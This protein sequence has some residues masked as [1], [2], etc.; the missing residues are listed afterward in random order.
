MYDIARE[1]RV[2]YTPA[3]AHKLTHTKTHTLRL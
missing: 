3:R 1:N 2:A